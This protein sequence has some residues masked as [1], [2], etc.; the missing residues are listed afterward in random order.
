MERVLTP[1]GPGPASR[2]GTRPRP[3]SAGPLNLAKQGRL[4]CGRAL[5]STALSPYK[6][7][8]VPKLD[9]QPLGL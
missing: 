8:P 6:A 3:R 7:W 5:G 9:T 2:M 1:R 4:S